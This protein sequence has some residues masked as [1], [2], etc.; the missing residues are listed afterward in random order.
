[1]CVRVGTTLP[2]PTVVRTPKDT[3]PPGSLPPT[4][5]RT[6]PTRTGDVVGGYGARGDVE[7]DL[8]G[9]AAGQS[10]HGTS[11]GRV[12]SRP[13]VPHTYPEKQDPTHP[14]IVQGTRTGEPRVTCR[15]VAYLGV[16]WSLG[17]GVTE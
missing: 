2:S 11:S 13:Y 16:N 17:Y 7:V 1:M 14:R 15:E 10:V 9:E 6:S 4:P 3:V 8:T 5:P 12:L